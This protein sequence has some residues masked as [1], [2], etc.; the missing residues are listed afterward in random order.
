MF[1][2]SIRNISIAKSSNFRGCNAHISLPRDK[3]HSKL[4]TS[5]PFGIVSESGILKVSPICK[6]L[7]LVCPK[8]VA[9]KKM[10]FG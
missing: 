4:L 7:S 1:K 5:N 9:K 2:L 10:K 8:C 3:N 6:N